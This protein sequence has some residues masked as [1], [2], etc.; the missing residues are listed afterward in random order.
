MLPATTAS[1][2]AAQ[3]TFRTADF[4]TADFRAPTSAVH[5]KDPTQSWYLRASDERG[6][7]ATILG[8]VQAKVNITVYNVSERFCLFA[9]NLCSANQNNGT[10]RPHCISNFDHVYI[11]AHHELTQH[12]EVSDSGSKHAKDR[13]NHWRPAKFSDSLPER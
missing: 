6:S 5:A 9:C 7:F 2:A 8:V 1:P 12:A 4:R 3:P 11:C 10:P 13:S